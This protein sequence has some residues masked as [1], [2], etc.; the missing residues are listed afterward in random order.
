MSELYHYGVK[1]MKWGIRK[2]R[3][4]T[5]EERKRRRSLERDYDIAKKYGQAANRAVVDTRKNAI[6]IGK[7]QKLLNDRRKELE[8]YVTELSKKYGREN[9]RQL[10]E[11]AVKR[12]K[13]TVSSLPK[14]YKISM[15]AGDILSAIAFGGGLSEAGR[16][17]RWNQML[18]DP[19]YDSAGKEAEDAW[20]KRHGK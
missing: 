2:D 10:K 8:N 6:T 18:S 11:E 15:T 13:Y 19:K 20:R 14:E 12:G 16:A 1:G 7:N 5:K 4:L 9:V 3:Y 17:S